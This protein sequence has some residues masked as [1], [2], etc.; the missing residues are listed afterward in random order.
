[1]FKILLADDNPD[2]RSSIRLLVETRLDVKLI[3]EASDME[4]VLVQVEDSQPDCI[5][6]DWRLPGLPTRER[7]S[8]LRSKLPHIKVII[9]NTNQNLEKLALAE[10]A[11]AFICKTDP[12]SKLLDVLQKLCQE[13]AGE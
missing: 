8:V 10:G 5:I 7:I 11:D 13:K 2:I 12:P 6:L 3:N 4:H 9:I 1:M